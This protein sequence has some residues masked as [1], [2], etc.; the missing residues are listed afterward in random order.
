MQCHLFLIFLPAPYLEIGLNATRPPD[1]SHQSVYQ[2]VN[3]YSGL[4]GATTAVTTDW[5][6]S[7]D[8]VRM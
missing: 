8:D 7:V 4:S 3:L 5:M 6:M 1:H 2:S